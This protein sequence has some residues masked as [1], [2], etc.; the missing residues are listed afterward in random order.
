MDFELT[1]ARYDRVHC[2]T[3]GL[4]R[5]LK[6]GERKKT[7]LDVKYTYGKDEY[8]RFIGFE[9]L[10]AD[11]MRLLQGLVALAGPEGILL[12]PTPTAPI[13]QQLRL[14]LEPEL[15]AVHRNGLVVRENISKLLH[16]IGLSDGGD[17]IKALKASLL[18]MSN[19]TVHIV[20]G[21]R[22]ASSNLLSYALNNEDGQMYVC[23]N[24]RIAEA[25]L[26]GRS[27]AKISMDEVRTIKSDPARLIH[28]RLCGW[29]NPGGTGAI[30]L[31]NL[32]EYVWPNQS[33]PG[34]MR[35]RRF[36]IR[37][38]LEELRELGWTINE[39]S[40]KRY[41]INRPPLP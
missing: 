28:Q 11:D 15:D 33:S 17:N 36:T 40:K 34:T 5:S 7:K 16:E 18:R 23:L 2:L 20:K 29:I 8:V 41:R 39:Y 32:C 37:K 25:V 31:D 1:H 3:P 24:Y 12:T 19:V 35:R 27:Y 38:N 21:K 14:K 4:F 26:G 9:P 22:E 30:T 10:G 13:A 6:R